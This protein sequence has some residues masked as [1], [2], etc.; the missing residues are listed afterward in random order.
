M[1]AFFPDAYP[2]ELLYSR[3]ARY[4][5]RSGYARYAFVASDLFK[6]GS[7]TLPS[8]EFVNQYTLDAMSWITKNDLF[9]TVL[10][11]HTMYPSYIRFL[12]IQKRKAA[13]EGM[14]SCN[15]N[16]KNLMHLPLVGRRYLRF[17]PL[18]SKIDREEYSEAYWHREHQ[19]QRIRV[20]PKHKCFLENSDVVISSKSSPA[21]YD[22][23]SVIVDKEI[24]PCNDEMELAFTQYVIDV[25]NERVD[26]KNAYPI[27]RYL[28]SWLNSKYLNPSGILR[29]MSLLYND[30][31]A[32]YGDMPVM[33]Q[34]YMQKIFN[35]YE[36][37]PYFVL[38][39]AYFSDISVY[40]ITHLPKYDANHGIKKLYYELSEKYA[41]DFSVVKEI[42][43]SVLEF[44]VIQNR[45][46]GKS[47]PKQIM[48][49][50]LDEKY[51]PEVKRVV[52]RILS[53]KGRPEKLSFSKV[54]KIMKLPQKQ[55][56]KLPKCKSYI[57]KRIESQP[58]FLAR[59]VE[60][61]FSELVKS[62]TPISLSKIMK[63]TNMRKTDI[64]CCVPYVKNEDVKI[65]LI[66]ST[67]R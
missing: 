52:K 23:E 30:Y 44:S 64:E 5:V 53:C 31:L 36:Y 39:I 27:G 55:I 37:D 57:E 19:L 12:P 41:L 7:L 35:G 50:E 40:D 43:N 49:D 16:W 4:Y 13:I 42:G 25:F 60:W 18:C 8:V 47:G 21:L 28:H 48:Y 2:D 9:E 22:A 24:I 20:C 10:E 62:E 33:S 3:L 32:F 45:V 17:C 29:N 46:S 6:N 58:R 51:L 26:M 67:K 34:T 54:E 65:F 61:A 1:I 15:G 14:I 63:L 59:E 66:Q 11:K 56:Y 38:Q